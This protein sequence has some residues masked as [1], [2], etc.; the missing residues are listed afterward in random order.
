M[1]INGGVPNNTCRYSILQ[2]VE[3]NPIPCPYEE[4]QWGEKQ[5]VNGEA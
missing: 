3:L 2:K 4:L 5:L 1:Q